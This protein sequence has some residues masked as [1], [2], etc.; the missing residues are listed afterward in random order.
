M[1]GIEISLKNRLGE[2]ELDV[3]FEAPAR[4]VTALFGRSGSGKTSVLRAVAGLVR[5]QQGKVTVNGT[6]WQDRGHFLPPHQRPLGYVFQEASLFPHLSVRGNLEYGWRR[7]PKADR[8]IKFDSVVELMGMGPLMRRATHRLSGGERQRVAIARAL[9]TSP[10]LL[11]MDEP[12]SSLDHSAK[13]AILP[14]LESLHDEFAIPSLYVSHDPNEVARL[15]DRMVIL[16]QGKVLATGPAGDLLTRLDLPMAIFD[17]AAATL[18]GTVSAHDHSFHL[19]WI[20]M[21]GGRVAV[22]REDLPVGRHARVRI[23]ARDVSLSLKAHSDTSIINILPAKVVDT[24]E[25]NPSQMIVRLELLDGQTLLS[26]ITRRSGI[27]LEL[28]EGM[29]LYAQVKSVALIG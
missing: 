11:L 25:I 24:Q 6:V 9:L 22:A 27:G 12:L 21:H 13:R 2:F 26:R 17:D 14:Y 19:T 28:H 3:A 23:Q 8:L 16:E 18:V 10:R 4:G 29:R 7:V 5:P 20:S 15:A 1:S